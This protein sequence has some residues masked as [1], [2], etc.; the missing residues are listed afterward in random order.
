MPTYQL[1]NEKLL[2]VTLQGEECFAKRGAMIATVGEIRFAPATLGSEGLQSGLARGLTS[3]NLNLMRATGRG[4][5]LYARRGLHIQILS[6]RGETL[7]IESESVLAYDG[8]LRSGTYFQGNS[9]GVGGLVRGAA[10]GQGL[11]T[12]TLEGQGEVAILSEGEAIALEV[13]AQKPV[14]VDPNAYI[15]HKGQLQ[16]SI[17]TDVGWKTLVGQGSGESFQLKFTGAGTL[18]VQ[19]SER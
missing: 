11:W 18:Y 10:T 14:F 9:G 17:H 19:P 3:E 15:G 16:S 8:R 4:T 5:V 12:T 13:S 2:E 6:L 1:R 7:Y